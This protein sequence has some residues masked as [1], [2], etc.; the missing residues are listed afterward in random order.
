[1][2]EAAVLVAVD[3]PEEVEVVAGVRV[4]EVEA[5]VVEE[6]GVAVAIGIAG[7]LPLAQ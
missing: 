1:V 2:K 7:S 4:A 3:V 6:A 5:G